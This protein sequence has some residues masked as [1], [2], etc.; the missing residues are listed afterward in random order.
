MKLRKAC[1]SSP[2]LQK[3]RRTK[4][5]FLFSLSLILIGCV[6]FGL[7]VFFSS[8]YISIKNFSVVGNKEISTDSLNKI[9]D[10]VKSQ[11]LFGLIDTDNFIFFDKKNF[12]GQVYALDPIVK[13]LDANFDGLKNLT[14][15]ISERSGFA[16]W[17]YSQKD[18]PEQ[19]LIVDDLGFAFK[20]FSKNDFETEIFLIDDKVS[21]TSPKIGDNFFGDVKKVV[22]L[23][24]ALEKFDW[25]V[26]R[27]AV[28]EGFYVISLKSDSE[29]KLSEDFILDETINKLDLIKQEM[30]KGNPLFKY[31][32]LRFSD[33]AFIKR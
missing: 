6:F 24:N 14:L 21:T 27:I 1:L 15:K 30:E 22:D 8:D 19:C 4:Y 3:K 33:R 10:N 18:L 20:K 29:I 11:K 16:V 25:K 23:A 17:C 12:L 7:N 26:Y 32:D 9:F 28:Y 31:I 2:K 13:D 5:F